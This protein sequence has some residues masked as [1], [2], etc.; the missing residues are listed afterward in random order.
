MIMMMIL[1]VM[2]VIILT[3]SY[4]EGFDDDIISDGYDFNDNTISD[5]DDYNDDT[6]RKT[7]ILM[8]IL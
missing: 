8:M 5:G 6:I 1:S 3:I 4:D 7:M 2:S